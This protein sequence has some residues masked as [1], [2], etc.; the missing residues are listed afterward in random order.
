MR[1]SWE[2]Q[3]CASREIDTL[4]RARWGP[5]ADII[6]ENLEL[7]VFNTKAVSV[8]VLFALFF[9]FLHKLLKSE[10]RSIAPTT[11]TPE[12]SFKACFTL[13][14]PFYAVCFFCLLWPITTIDLFVLSDSGWPSIDA[15]RTFWHTG[16]QEEQI[17]VGHVVIYY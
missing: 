10:Q 11:K 12:L 5:T 16:Y 17:Q 9:E 1:I 8:I 3:S 13:K 7:L 15:S 4:W 6:C 14:F 2:G